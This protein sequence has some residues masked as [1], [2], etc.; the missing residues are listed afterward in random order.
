MNGLTLV[1][2]GPPGV[3]DRLAGALPPGDEGTEHTIAAMVALI[4]EAAKS[5]Q[6]RSL[7]AHLA[8][9]R[10][11]LEAQVFFWLKATIKFHKDPPHLE[12]LRHPARMID[13]VAAGARIGKKPIG[14]CDD[15]ADLA[16]AVIVASGAAPVLVVVGPDETG[17]FKHVYAGLRTA[18]S[19]IPLD[20]QELSA[21]GL[22]VEAARRRVFDVV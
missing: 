22:E 10:V 5:E 16:A 13:A 6:V 9:T 15:V 1:V 19:Y 11:A 17:P 21:P 4:R 18:Q 7:A 14:D 8:Q 12:F 3:E 20:P 2:Q